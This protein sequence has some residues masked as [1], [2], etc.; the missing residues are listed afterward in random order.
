MVLQLHVR[1]QSA[2]GDTRDHFVLKLHGLAWRLLP[3]LLSSNL[4]WIAFITI[5][6]T[7]T[8]A[9]FTTAS[10]I[11]INCFDFVTLRSHRVR[12]LLSTALAF[13]QKVRAEKSVPMMTCTSRSFVSWG[14]CCDKDLQQN[15]CMKSEQK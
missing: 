12:N 7:T 14:Q 8:T 4:H 9:I 6:T 11:A 3:A 15:N 2:P 13:R 5:I 1:A 10:I